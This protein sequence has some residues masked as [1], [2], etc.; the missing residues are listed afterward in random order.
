M[1]CTKIKYFSHVRHNKKP[2]WIDSARTDEIGKD[3]DMKMKN[4]SSMKFFIYIFIDD[5]LLIINYTMASGNCDS[6]ILEFSV[7]NGILEAI[8][9]NL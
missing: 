9:S 6:Y 3:L 4:I 5:L 7:K 1:K 2:S 8:Q